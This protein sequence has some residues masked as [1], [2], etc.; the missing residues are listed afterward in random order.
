MNAEEQK[1]EV[2]SL[3][4]GAEASAGMKVAIKKNRI[5]V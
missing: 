4:K 1:Q 5:N 3:K 2:V